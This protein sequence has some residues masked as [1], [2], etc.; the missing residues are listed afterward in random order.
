M[1]NADYHRPI[2]FNPRSRKE[3]DVNAPV[4]AKRKRDFN[5]RSRKE[6][7]KKMLMKFCEL[8]VFQST[9][10]QGERLA[11]HRNITTAC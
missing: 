2:N 3:S 7:D 5:P 6:S 10:S 4:S 1:R 11:S 9:L 8:I